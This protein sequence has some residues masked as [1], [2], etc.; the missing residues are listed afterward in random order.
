MTPREIAD[1][2]KGSGRTPCRLAVAE[3][4]LAFKGSRV[5]RFLR[6][7]IDN[8]IRHQM[9]DGAGNGVAPTGKGR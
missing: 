2:V 8:W 4:I 9:S 6:K 7:G 3:Q 1:Y 5:W